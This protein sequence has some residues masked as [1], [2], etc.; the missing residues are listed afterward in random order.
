MK[1]LVVLA[2]CVVMSMSM[3]VGCGGGS[4]S[5]SVADAEVTVVDGKEML[6]NMYLEGDKIVEET[7]TFD[8]MSTY[9]TR[10]TNFGEMDLFI[11]LEEKS[12]VDIEWELV[13]T[14]DWTQKKNLK[15]AS[16]TYP[17]AFFSGITDTDVSTYAQQGVFIELDELIANY[18]PN[19]QAI[20]DKYPD[21]K[22]SC[23]ATDGKIYSLSTIIVD[24]GAYNPDQLFINKTW[25]DEL[26]LEVPKTMDDFYNVL[27]AFKNDDP[28]GNGVADEIPYSARFDNYIQGIHSL[29]GAYGRI[30]VTGRGFYNHFVVEEDGNLVFTADTEEYKTAITELHKYFEE[31]L[32]DQEIFTQ[33]S[34]QYFAK[35]Q[36]EEM[37]LGAFTLWNSENMVGVDRADDYIPLSPMT[38]PDGDII[39]TEELSGNSPST[40]FA[41]TNQCENPEILIRWVDQFFAEELS[42][43]AGWGP[44]SEA[45]EGEVAAFEAGQVG[46]GFDDY[47]YQQAPIWGPLAV[48]E[49]YYERVVETPEM[50]S[51]KVSIM[52]EYY[53]EYM[54]NATLP[55]L[56][57]TE[58][59]TDW[60]STTGGDIVNH[61]ADYQSKWLLN[62]GIEEE[63][64]AYIEGLE[65]L[66]VE[67][68]VEHMNAAYDRYVNQ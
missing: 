63:W 23:T 51:S 12:N 37:T 57:F 67:Q 55:I 58:E 35:G 41:I 36:T 59:E 56:K 48:Y 11:E 47:R 27:T 53:A 19:I 65:Q 29:F 7:V 28:N 1:K 25:L 62:G 32:F 42:V 14:S 30:D 13:A 64:D 31:G 18:A 9:E 40:T 52:E 15:L 34:K 6:G 33:D 45:A 24:P 17:D 50:M 61:I 68:H 16:G 26:G 44:I 10:Q 39:W 60:F 5:Q 3:V 22:A 54:T 8:L 43:A 2:L 21:Y 20:L 46:Q 4:D 38:G 49:D 66:N